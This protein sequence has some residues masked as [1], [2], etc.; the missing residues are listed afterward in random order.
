MY[1]RTPNDVEFT[2]NDVDIFSLTIYLVTLTEQQLHAWM[3]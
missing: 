1:Q 2:V 3:C